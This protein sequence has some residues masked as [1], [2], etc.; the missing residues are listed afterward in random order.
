MNI[1]LSAAPPEAAGLP[2]ASSHEIIAAKFY[3]KC[4]L[5]ALFTQYAPRVVASADVR[6]GHRVLDVACGTGVVSREAAAVSGE[7]ALVT[8]VDISPGMLAVARDIRPTIDWRLG[9]AANLPFADAVFDRVV[10]QFGLMF[11]P[12]PGRALGEMLRVLKP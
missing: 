9:D 12:D 4:L 5:P 7:D 11:F 6:A 1:A 2:P 8:G 3:E 10:C